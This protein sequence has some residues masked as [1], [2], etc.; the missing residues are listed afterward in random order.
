MLA[1]EQINAV[2]IKYRIVDDGVCNEPTPSLSDGFHDQVKV[3][4]AAMQGLPTTDE[5][6]RSILSYH[7]KHRIER[8]TGSYISNGAVIAAA[9][10]L[11]L[12]VWLCGDW[13]ADIGLNKRKAIF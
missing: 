8:A 2:S 4:M 7:L 11:G 5:R 12:R 6:W 1:I 13:N 10:L 3:A 9:Y